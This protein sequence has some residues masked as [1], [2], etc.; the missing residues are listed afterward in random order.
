MIKYLRSF[1]IGSLFCIA[2]SYI[3]V[4][5]INRSGNVI[6][7]G[8]QISSLSYWFLVFLVIFLNP[9][10]RFFRFSILKSRELIIIATMCIAPA[11][12]AGYAFV[13]HFIP[14]I[15]SLNNPK[16][17]D[18][19]QEYIVPN[20]QQKLYL[21]T[22]KAGFEAYNEGLQARGKEAFP[23]FLP[24]EG[25]ILN[26]PNDLVNYFFRGNPQ[27]RSFFGDIPWHEWVLP[28]FLWAMFFAI[29]IVFFYTLNQLMFKQWFVN[30]K[31]IFP[32][33]ELIQSVL[34]LN[35]NSSTSSNKLIYLMPFF[36][37][38]FSISFFVLFYNGTVNANWVPG[39]SS[40]PLSAKLQP[41]VSNTWLEPLG[42]IKFQIYF[43]LIGLGFLLP[44]E[45]TFSIWLFFLLYQFQGFIAV[46][47]GYVPSMQSL[48]GG[49]FYQAAFLSA[50][51]GGALVVFS[52]ICLW[53]IRHNLFAFIYK[54]TRPSDAFWDQQEIKANA[55]TS[56]VFVI[57]SVSIILFFL[58]AKVDIGF[59]I[60][61]YVFILFLT[62]ICVRLVAETGLMS[63]QLWFGPLHLIQSL[64]L[65]KLSFLFKVKSLVNILPIY[66]PIFL[67]VKTFLASTMMTTRALAKDIED[68]FAFPIAIGLGFFISL[69]V[70]VIT[71]L[72]LIYN[73]GINSMF[74]WF[75]RAFPNRVVFGAVNTFM[76]NPDRLSEFPTDNFLGFIIGSLT[77]IGLL[78]ARKIF[79]WVPHPIGMFVYIN[80]VIHKIWFSVFLAWVFKNFCVKYLKRDSYENVKYA[81][82][83]IFLGHLLVAAIS[84]IVSTLDLG[85]MKI[86]LN[87]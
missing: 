14:T 5:S 25:A 9:L 29:I 81:F 33:T 58:W 83:G 68:K 74:G 37:F 66:A 10:L 72:A 86:E 35:R 50:Q 57:A 43:A 76:E 28:L 13:S 65:L 22:D 63:F 8:N 40:I 42:N 62:I 70:A 20:A 52:S 39:L 26:Y 67:D 32:H 41:Y 79:F 69:V 60:L 77:M 16:W 84:A 34:G 80:P 7:P 1:I 87:R 19:Y 24:R 73:L 47:T 44:A 64:G 53:K 48:G 6:L 21:Q 12:V 85:S 31:L 27:N 51:G 23:I 3:A 59:A 15:G 11:G 36:W 61:F 46:H 49:F 82:T 75:Y 54:Y 30:E 17:T 38:G 45:I 55:S 4:I 56:L 18:K 78:M 71:S 2:F